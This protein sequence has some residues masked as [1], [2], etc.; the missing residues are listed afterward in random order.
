YIRI[1]D[2]SFESEETKDGTVLFIDCEIN[3][4]SDFKGYSEV[5]G[6]TDAV[7][8]K[9]NGIDTVINKTTVQVWNIT[10]IDFSRDDDNTR[11]ANIEARFAVSHN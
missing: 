1:G 8:G 3:I 7:L 2:D 10:R 6:L 9:L 4:Y 11:R 5:K